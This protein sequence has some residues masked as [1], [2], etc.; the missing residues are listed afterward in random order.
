MQLFSHS[1]AFFT[2]RLFHAEP[3]IAVITFVIIMTIIKKIFHDY[4]PTN[5][6]MQYEK[7]NDNKNDKPDH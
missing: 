1:Q 5:Y 6:T 3:G 2:V 7:A 4:N